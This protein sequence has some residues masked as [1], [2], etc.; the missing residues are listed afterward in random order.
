MLPVFS[1]ASFQN[2]SRSFD[3]RLLICGGEQCIQ[4]HFRFGLIG[5]ENQWSPASRE[6]ADSASSAQVPPQAT[7]RIFS[8]SPRTESIPST[9]CRM[10][11]ALASSLPASNKRMRGINRDQDQVMISTAEYV[12]VI[13]TFLVDNSGNFQACADK[14]P[15]MPRAMKL[16]CCYRTCLPRAP[17]RGRGR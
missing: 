1:T 15:S 16:P 3:F 7:C 14:W 2:A 13:Q 8:T 6:D 17:A 12:I 9:V 5:L 10:R 4:I 11:S